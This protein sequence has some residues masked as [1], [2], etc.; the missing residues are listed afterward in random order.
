MRTLII[1]NGD[2][3]KELIP[4]QLTLPGKYE[5]II[6]CNR[7]FVQ[8]D[9][10]ATRHVVGEKTTLY[11]KHDIPDI[12]NSGNYS[13]TLPRYINY[14]GIGHYDKRYNLIPIIRKPRTR[15]FKRSVWRIDKGYKVLIEGPKCNDT[16]QGLGTVLL[17]AVHLACLLGTTKIHIY[18]A[19]LCFKTEEDHFYGGRI[20]RDNVCEK[21]KDHRIITLPDGRKTLNYFANSA[22][23]ANKFL[24]EI[25][26]NI[27]ITDYSNG[28]LE[29]DRK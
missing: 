1:C 24:C 16:G 21:N 15:N 10:I 8:F 4:I 3:A 13:I 28:L 23:W 6:I 27:K 18:G 29:L 5:E 17:Q 19:D 20:Y 14:K 9:N 12:L 2:S 11:N 25:F 7:G 26:D 22:Q